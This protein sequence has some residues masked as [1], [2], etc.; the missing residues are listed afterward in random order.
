MSETTFYLA[1]RDLAHPNLT[2]SQKR[3][4]GLDV[5]ARAIVY[6]SPGSGKT[7]ALREL[8]LSQLRQ[9][10]DP[11]Q[12][13]VLAA[14]RE[15]ANTL[16][17]DLAL[18]Y[19]SATS[20]PLAR[21]VTSFAFQL[22]RHDALARGV[23]APEL[24][25]GAE[26]DLL[27]AE[28]IAQA[29]HESLPWPKHINEQVLSLK[30]FR[31]ELRELL[32][33][34][35]EHNLT[36][37]ELSSLAQEAESPKWVAASVL[38]E[39][40]LQKLRQ[41]E[42]E[43]RHDAS[44]LLT[45]ATELLVN[46]AN[47]L[48]EVEQIRLILVDDAQELTPAAKRLLQAL[49]R[50]GVGLVLFGD[51]DAAT[52]GF[53][54]ADPRSMTILMRSLSSEFQQV[55]LRSEAAR[56][57]ELSKVLANIS[58]ELPSEH[59]GLQ[60]RDY[61]PERTL[62]EDT[63]SIESYVFNDAISEVAA[64]ARRL[65]ELHLNEKL[66][67][68]QV[69]IVARSRSILERFE[70]ALAAESVPAAIRGSRQA[71]RDSFAARN[72][73]EIAALVMLIANH[74]HVISTDEAKRLMLSPFCGI[75]SLG[76]RRLRRVLRRLELD[77][78]GDRN[79]DQLIADLFL[80]RGS[81]SE[82][83]TSEARTA[84]KFLQ[85]IFDAIDLV[86]AG[87]SIEQVLWTI[88]SGSTAHRDWV[89]QSENL[90]EVG[91]QINQNLD[92]LVAL[93]G[94]ANRF[95]ERYPEAPA[96]K[97]VE[98]QL[99]LDLPED[100]LE[101]NYRDDNRVDLVTPAGL[102]GRRYRVIIVVQL[103]EGI[104]PN[105]KPRSSLLGAMNLDQFLSQRNEKVETLSRNELPDELRMLHKAVGA[106]SERLIVTAVDSEDQQVSSFFRTM[107]GKI[108][109]AQDFSRPRFTLRGMVGQLRRTL[110]ESRDSAE[111]LASAVGLAR[112][113]LE[114]TPGAHPENWYGL[115]PISTTE[116]LF[117]LDQDPDS[118]VWLKPSQLENFLDCPLHWFLN[119]HGGSD[120]T[121][122]TNLGI[123]IHSALE[124]ENGH[125][126]EQLWQLIEHRFDAIDFE[127]DWLHSRERAKAKRMLGVM[128]SYLDKV[129]RDGVEVV[130][131]E[132]EFRFKL[133]R[134][135]VNGK[136]D[137]IERHPDGSIMIVDLKTSATITSVDDAQLHPQLGLYQLAF[138]A[139]AFSHVE[140]IKAGD[141]LTG[142]KLLFVNAKKPTEREQSS[143]SKDEAKKAHFEQIVHDAVK[144][145][146]LTDQVFVA[147]VSSHCNNANSYGQCE[148]HIA[149]AVTY[150]G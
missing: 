134:A 124:Q 98:Q 60:R 17:D 58:A 148:I 9:G 37:G 44:T 52:L 84:A 51:P 54:A 30:G 69:A 68:S 26:Q 136:V 66:P 86:K 121:F 57:P 81:L 110:I 135:L 18:A 75:D 32:T 118:E 126:P 107:F 64:V 20:G 150:V 144:D 132:V 95:V 112:L 147:N 74:D 137:R 38:L 143:I 35:L 130:G 49:V 46:T 90:D 5:S 12:I 117:D 73:L 10:L 115:L 139:G 116:P 102:I 149:K 101:M 55:V 96:Q 21:T 15:A 100:S 48:P 2:E 40:Y 79:A 34:C 77:I 72:L 87:Q 105:L 109:E 129:S 70:T 138:E 142:A 133:G 83:N 120:K 59:A 103:Q 22:L 85:R 25:S 78:E 47:L 53:R 82:I 108:P 23:R 41:P 67:W 111:R 61:V 50:P 119:A 93:F 88:F 11:N 6:G 106:A 13:L 4:E 43:N 65:R 128:S 91:A 123:L 39:S 99:A 125:T 56:N 146:A 36:P 31:A 140:G 89:R 62:L 114:G 127:A 104:W 45:V 19:Q 24:I 14:S 29:D 141:Q 80:A 33:V 113:S 63:S 97:F 76:L 94:A 16:R 8:A 3:V 27:L 1:S 131:R 145:M 92:S 122:E 71:L 42:F 28:V 7:T